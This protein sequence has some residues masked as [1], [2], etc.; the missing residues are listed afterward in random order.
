MITVSKFGGTSVKDAAAIKRLGSILSGKREKIV[1]VVS[2]MSKVTDGLISI[3]NFLSAGNESDALTQLKEVFE[4]HRKTASELNLSK[5]LYDEI[6]FK[7]RELIQLIKALHVLGEISPKSYDMIVSTGEI[8]SSRI[9]AAYLQSCKLNAIH[10]DS[11][12]IIRTDSCFSEANIDF[13]ITDR[14]VQKSMDLQFKNFEIV[15]CGGFIGSDKTG[16]TTTLGRGGSDYSAAVIASALDAGKL[17]IWTDV[18]GIMTSDPRVIK[19]ARVIKE[20]TYS[21]ASELAYFGAKVLHP[22]TIQPAVAKNIPVWVLNSFDS[23]HPGTKI[24]ANSPHGKII[25]AIAFRR[26]IT[27]ISIASNRMLGAYGFLSKVFEVFS[28]YETPVDIITTS[29][30][31]ISLTIDDARNLNVIKK[32]LKKI[33]DVEVRNSYGIICAVGEGIRD[34][35]GIAARFFGVLKGINILMVSIG[36]SEINISI[37]VQ[38][39]DID[40]S[41]SLLHKE[42]FN[43]LNSSIFY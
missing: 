10:T 32:E 22:K 43:K 24:V 19:K 1:V 13:K 6:D 26:N 17:E 7:E 5:T 28:K 4:K 15:V 37:I 2:A 40:K 33:G 29:E 21:E 23:D 16:N 11:R 30:V 41:V 35:S 42:F 25:K 38:D 3:I 27:V 9:V 8:L 20:L 34:T 14:L 12:K 36:A 18:S 31:S 39:K